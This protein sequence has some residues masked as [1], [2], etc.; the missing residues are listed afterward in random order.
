MFQME[1]AMA[2]NTMGPIYGNQGIITQGQFGNNTIIQGPIPRHLSEPRAQSLKDQ[3]LREIP[4][5]KPI[6]VMAIM[7]DAEAMEF[8]NEI[9]SFLKDNGFDLSE[10]DGISQGVFSG[11]VKGVVLRKENNGSLTFIIGTNTP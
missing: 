6:T 1:S 4:K 7:G 5:D 11:P 9:H 8:A 3:I 2:Q 10:P